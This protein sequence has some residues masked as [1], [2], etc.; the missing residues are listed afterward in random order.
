MQKDTPAAL[1]HIFPMNKKIIRYSGFT[2]ED[3]LS[4]LANAKARGPL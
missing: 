4:K 1:I 3:A 2:R